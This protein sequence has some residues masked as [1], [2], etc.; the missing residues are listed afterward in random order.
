MCEH[1]QIRPV[2]IGEDITSKNRQALSVAYPQVDER[3]SAAN[4]RG[5]TMRRAV[6][7]GGPTLDLRTYR[8]NIRL[9]AL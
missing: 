6:N 4:P 8:G 7:G 5:G 1:D 3:R 2:H 9:R